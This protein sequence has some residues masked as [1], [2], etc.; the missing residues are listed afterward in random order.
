[1]DL[2]ACDTDA[3]HLPLEPDRLLRQARRN[4]RTAHGARAVTAGDLAD[5]DPELR[6]HAADASR[7]EV[8]ALLERAERRRLALLDAVERCL[9]TGD[10]PADAA[11]VLDGETGARIDRR[12]ALGRKNEGSFVA[13]RGG[14]E[15]PDPRLAA[16]RRQL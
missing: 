7:L 13:D 12:I 3:M 8:V 1:M 10:R 16:A 6:Q 9:Q 15:R 14:L 4:E 11:G 2:G 5:V